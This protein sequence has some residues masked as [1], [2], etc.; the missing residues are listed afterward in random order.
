MCGI[1]GIY[2]FDKNNLVNKTLLKSM[3]DEIRHRGPDDEGYYID[4]NVGLGFRRL[5]IIDISINGH[6]PMCN[7]DESVWIIFNGEFYNFQD[8]RN[9]LEAKGHRFKSRTDS[10]VI[11]H[12]YEEYGEK[13]I[14]KING[15]FAFC[16]YDKKKQQVL[17]ARDRIGIKPLYY[18]LD[19]SRLIFASEIKA[20]IK[21]PSIQR[22]INYNSLSNFL[23]NHVIIG[24]DTIFN[25]I[26]KLLPGHF[27]KIEN[28]KIQIKEYWDLNFTNDFISCDENFFVEKI[29]ELLSSSVNLQL[30]SDVPLGVFLSGGVDSSGVVAYVDKI[31]GRK[32][33]TQS[34]SISFIGSKYDESRY[35][36][37]VSKLYQTIHTE[38]DLKMDFIKSVPK[39]VWH[40]DEPF[41]DSSAFATYHLAKMARDYVTVVLTGDG[42]DEIFAGYP[43]RYS[44]DR[45]FN[46]VNFVP[47][48]FRSS[49]YNL[50]KLFP[51][52]GS[53][54]LKKKISDTKQYLKYLSKDSDTAFLLSF[55]IFDEKE[56]EKLLQEKILEKIN[57]AEEIERVRKYRNSHNG[58]SANILQQRLYYDIKTMLPDQMLTKVD[59]MTMASSLEARPPILDH[60]LVELAMNIPSN[61]KIKNRNGKLILKK[62]FEK[63]LPK[64]ILYRK[65]SGFNVPIEEWFR[66][67]LKEYARG[68]LSEESIRKRGL[69]KYSYIDKLFDDHSKFKTNNASKIFTLISLEVWFQIFID[70]TISIE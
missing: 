68:I 42:G 4:K 32:N 54:E 7:E 26:H 15:M 19:N 60:R 49:A 52:I 17:L 11:I 39:I 14:E 34:F 22:N 44:M 66:K 24:E 59:K 41:S 25:N 65:K 50:S 20:I 67:D 36:R 38:F 28:N 69:F 63:Y 53:K 30:I 61:F 37:E 62:T 8:Y 35:A 2:N 56:Q 3:T 47:E 51:S 13:C 23:T 43:F 9:E 12:L 57:L 21:D 16:I 55:S 48:V 18:F 29:D 40:L 10:E 46:R 6:Q 27:L 5:S 64:E 31:K 58:S 1:V 45:R 70:K 33:K